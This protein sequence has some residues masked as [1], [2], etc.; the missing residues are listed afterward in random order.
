MVEGSIPSGGSTYGPSET[1][2]LTELVRTMRLQQCD[3]EKQVQM[4][5]NV[6]NLLAES[7]PATKYSA[8]SAGSR[9]R[10][11]RTR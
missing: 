9:T 11:K 10:A 5:L 8:R 4:L 6:L 3:N 7:K 1:A 2:R